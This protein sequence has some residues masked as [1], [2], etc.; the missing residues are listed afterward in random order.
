M[1]WRIKAAL[2][3]AIVLVA[4]MFIFFWVSLTL[5]KGHER[6]VVLL[7]AAGGAVAICAAMLVGLAVL[8]D[9]P[10]L[11]LQE[12]IARLRDG[13][14][15]VT[16]TFAARNDEIGDL[17]RNFNAMVGQIRATQEEIRRLH[18]TQM[19]RAEHL[20]TLGEL[21]AG[22][23]HEIRNPL[24]GISGVIEIIGRDLPPSSP[25]A[26]VWGDVRNEMQRVQKIL[27]ELLTYARPKPPEYKATDLCSTVDH[28]VHLAR[29][30]AV[31]KPIAIE[32]Q[33]AAGIP[34]VEHDATQIEQ[35]LVNLL[36]NS[37]QA[38][39]REGRIE[40]GIELVG[41]SAQI[42]VRDSGRGIPPEQLPNIFRPFFTTKGHGT[43]LGLSLAKRIVESHGG[44]IEVHS[45]LNRGTQFT[46]ALPLKRT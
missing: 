35:M 8:V 9:R 44:Q 43:G 23:A 33:C 11:E 22:L 7:V 42:R 37:I 17:G 30:H 34:P 36:L 1:K 38:I 28:A 13:D 24:A 18:Q 46:I 21:A 14:L 2:P 10:L 40:V 20:A 39:E 25:G 26:Q 6:Q 27:N 16:A 29:Q 41:E 12:K 45:E 5:D 15:N 31:S 4:G 19:S 3:V 32:L